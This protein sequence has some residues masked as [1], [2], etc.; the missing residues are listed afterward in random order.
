MD[1]L[2]PLSHG[3]APSLDFFRYRRLSRPQA[4]RSGHRPMLLES[5]SDPLASWPTAFARWRRFP[6]G[7]SRAIPKPAAP[8]LVDASSFFASADIRRKVAGRS[9]YSKTCNPSCR[10]PPGCPLAESPALARGPCNRACPSD[11]RR[12]HHARCLCRRREGAPCP[13]PKFSPLPAV[14]PKAPSWA[15]RAGPPPP[16]NWRA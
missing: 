7:W 3:P 2:P 9:T 11:L 10:G 15:A 12:P 4:T 13:C 14:N 6:E 1:S 16:T 8:F 5:D